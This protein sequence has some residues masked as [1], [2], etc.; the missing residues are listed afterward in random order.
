MVAITKQKK[1]PTT[2]LKQKQ[3]LDKADINVLV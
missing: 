3:G 1:W 2:Q